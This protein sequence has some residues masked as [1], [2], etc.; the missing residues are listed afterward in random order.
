MTIVSVCSDLHLNWGDCILPGGDILLIAGDLTEKPLESYVRFFD[1]ELRK[2]CL[3]LVVLGNHDL[4]G[5]YLNEAPQVWRDFLARHAP[6]AILL[7]NEWVE[8]D[9]VRFIGS[10]LWAT[11]GYGTANHYLIQK[12]M[13]DFRRIKKHGQRF[14]V[15]HLNE[16]HLA[17][18]TFLVEAVKT[19]D[20]C[21]LMTHH[22]PTYL[23]LNR[24]RFPDSRFD[25]AYCA[26]LHEFILDNPQIRMAF[27]GHSHYRYRNRI[28]ET[29]VAANPRG[30]HG[31]PEALGFNP[32]E[33]DW[34]LL[35][36][37]FL[38]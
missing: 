33:L 20:P 1:E 14:L 34:D 17:A 21:V 15:G 9:G 37:E 16:L 13:N 24:K 35:T 8:I 32:C 23:A 26:N 2:Y 29:K 18:K 3:V 31:T 12:E 10:A 22:A 19:D 38:A 5:M 27:H 6:N 36:F 7:G 30:Y 28:G 4:W 11:Y 25:D